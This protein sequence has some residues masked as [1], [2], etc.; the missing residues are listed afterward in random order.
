VDERKDPK[1]ERPIQRANMEIN[2]RKM[3]VEQ[4]LSRRDI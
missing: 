3:E 4:I 1:Q 2:D